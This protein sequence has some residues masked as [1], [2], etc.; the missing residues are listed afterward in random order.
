MKSRLA[1]VGRFVLRSRSLLPLEADCLLLLNLDEHQVVGVASQPNAPR[2][3]IHHGI[4]QIDQQRA[5][6]R[7][8][9]CPTGGLGMLFDD[10]AGQTT[11]VF[12]RKVDWLALGATPM[13]RSRPL[14]NK[15]CKEGRPTVKSMNWATLEAAAAKP[16]SVNWA[17]VSPLPRVSVERVALLMTSCTFLVY[18]EG[19]VQGRLLLDPTGE[20]RR[21]AIGLPDRRR[22]N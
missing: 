8:T 2:S 17:T 5:C 19:I 14:E 7:H 22:N 10:L 21:F 18:E 20:Q 13:G 12:G 3:R 1:L 15:S 4:D 9:G 11:A 6:L 16:G